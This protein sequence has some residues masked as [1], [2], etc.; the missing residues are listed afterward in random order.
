VGIVPDDRVLQRQSDAL[1]GID[2]TIEAAKAWL[3]Q[4]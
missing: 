4:R 2:T 3:L 1:Q